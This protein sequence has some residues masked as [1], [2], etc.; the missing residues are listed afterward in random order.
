MPLALTGSLTAV[1]FCCP[2]ELSLALN[3][4]EHFSKVS[5]FLRFFQ[6]EFAPGAVQ[7]ITVSVRLSKTIRIS[8]N[9][10]NASNEMG[11]IRAIAA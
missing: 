7:T 6:A 2:A 5:L 11:Y 3:K 8:L 1:Q 10:L 4:I 9:T